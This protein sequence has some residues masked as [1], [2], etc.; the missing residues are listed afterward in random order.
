[1]PVA[2]WL[3]DRSTS[4]GEAI[5][6]CKLQS[7]FVPILTLRDRS[8]RGLAGGGWPLSACAGCCKLE[9]SNFVH[10]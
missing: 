2:A 1:M 7:K 9:V 6:V 3:L 5:A 10:Q 4:V 8:N